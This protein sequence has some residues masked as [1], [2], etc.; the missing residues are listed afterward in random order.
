MKLWCP[1]C[2]RVVVKRGKAEHWTCPECDQIIEADGGN[3]F[4]G[5]GRGYRGLGVP[6]GGHVRGLQTRPMSG[7][8]AR[9]RRSGQT[10]RDEFYVR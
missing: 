9:C 4:G 8:A 1:A 6:V 5:V 3:L 2:D 10:G 7:K